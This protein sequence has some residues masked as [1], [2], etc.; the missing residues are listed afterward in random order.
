MTRNRTE[1]SI[2]TRVSSLMNCLLPTNRVAVEVNKPI[3]TSIST[4]LTLL[5]DDFTDLGYHIQQPPTADITA[6]ISSHFDLLRIEWIRQRLK[7]LCGA[8]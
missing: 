2:E 7:R 3:E 6:R 1:Q 5:Q 8:Q 4:D